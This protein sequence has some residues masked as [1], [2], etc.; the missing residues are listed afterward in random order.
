MTELSDEGL[1][2]LILGM[3]AGLT[4]RK[5]FPVMLADNPVEHRPEQGCFILTT[6]SGLRYMVSV[7]QLK[8]K[9]EEKTT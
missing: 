7:D 9:T 4:L 1:G 6:K 3:F 8:S 5:D 2:I